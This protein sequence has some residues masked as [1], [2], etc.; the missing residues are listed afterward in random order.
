MLLQSYKFIQSNQENQRIGNI[1]P[2]IATRQGN[3]T[4]KY[5][6]TQFRNYQVILSVI[7]GIQIYRW[8]NLKPDHRYFSNI[9]PENHMRFVTG[10]RR[11]Y[12]TLP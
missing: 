11:N 9:S 1:E 10:E 12:F 5:S 7:N 2:D 6:F 8:F 3:K 4:E